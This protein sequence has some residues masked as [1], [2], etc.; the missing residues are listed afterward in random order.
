MR[1]RVIYQSSYRNGRELATL[2]KDFDADN[3]EEARKKARKIVYSKQNELTK[4]KILEI[5][6]VRP[7]KVKKIK[8][9]C[10]LNDYTPNPVLSIF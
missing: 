5:Q 6:R 1:Y 10:P 8:P 7:E 9:W 3:N 4:N 2:S